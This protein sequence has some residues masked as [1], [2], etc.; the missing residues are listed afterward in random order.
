MKI[1]TALEGC[2]INLSQLYTV[3][4]IMSA[5]CATL[6][7]FYM[8]FASRL[9]LAFVIILILLHVWAA[10]HPSHWNWGIH[11]F[12]FYN[13]VVG[14]IA[15]IAL[16][17]VATPN[18]QSTLLSIIEQILQFISKLSLIIIFV[19]VTGIVIGVTFLFS[20]QLHLLGDG[21]ILLR[22][23][24]GT[25]WGNEV[26][27]S[28]RN[29]PFMS[30]IYQSVINFFPSDYHT[31]SLDVY[32]VI[33]IVATILF[34]AL[35][36]WFFQS[37]QRPVL[38]KFLLGCFLFFG[39]GSQFFFGYVENYVLQYVVIAGFIVTGWFT[40]E[41]KVPVIVPAVCFGMMAGLHR[42]SLIFLPSLLL[43][44]FLSAKKDKM[45]M[46]LLLGGL[47]VLTILFFIIVNFD[48]KEFI[49]HLKTGSVDFLP[50]F[51]VDGGS[52]P[53]PMFSF[54]HLVDWLNA[55]LLVVPFGLLIAI[56]L[57]ATNRK[58][59]SWK[60]PV[61]LFLFVSA[62]CGLLFTWIINASL[63]M[64]RDWD[65]LAS[66]F[67]PLMFLN[68]Y[69]LTQ[70][71]SLEPR[72]YILALIVA[73]TFVHWS[74]WIGVNANAQ[75]HLSRIRLLDDS[76]LL[77]LSSQLFYNEALANYFF[78][79]KEYSQAQIYY[80]NFM[81]IDPDN[82]RILGNISDVYRKGGKKEKYFEI[83]KRA[84]ALNSPDPGI[85]SNLGVEYAARGDT[86]AAITFNQ[87]AIAMDSTQEKAHA[88]LGL[89]Y[90]S[91]DRFALADDHFMKAINL[92]MREPLVFRYAAD[93]CVMLEDF[94]RALNLYDI[95][96]THI[97]DDQRVRN[98]R[99][100]IYENISASRKK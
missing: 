3:G 51:S 57:L 84:T 55:N 15:I 70:T 37:S 83:L 92:G 41:K 46:L 87:K 44:G 47:S 28:F 69:L 82:P 95:Y 53:Y 67:V 39:A 86:A 62:C 2:N 18:I 31:R 98:I 16:L 10:V 58:E 88:N 78:G 40:L 19:V 52:F 49:N 65:L 23:I 97:P 48:V 8:T 12:G 24:P 43:L 99:D 75:K 63:G 50:P 6:R 76:R 91:Q 68:V 1:Q 61:F 100:R 93:V 14:F 21:A 77:A 32:V 20:A 4:W 85:Y 79:T 38:E 42:G 7:K 80:E 13:P 66:F 33:N 9:F 72:Q 27:Q 29:Q 25:I 5:I 64:A 90:A 60:N 36:F 45:R 81:K 96:L 73:V 94:Q 17:L 89:L 56:V 11:F 34:L 30:S 26:I 71:R 59:I 74:S 35:L 54:L 22:S